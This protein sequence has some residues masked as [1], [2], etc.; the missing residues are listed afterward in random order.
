M[1]FYTII[2][3]V[4]ERSINVK[5]EQIVVSTNVLHITGT[6]AELIEGEAYSV[7][8]ML[9]GLMLP[10][11]ND[12]ANE[13]AF[14]AGSYLTDSK[15]CRTQQKTFVAE[16]NRHAKNLNLFNTKFANPHGLPHS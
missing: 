12:A 5:E 7:E 16:M 11:G 4:E 8:A 3:L 2:K 10:S 13:L 14:W 6:S 1:T 15:E 9:Y